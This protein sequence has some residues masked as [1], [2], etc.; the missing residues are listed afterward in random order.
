MQITSRDHNEQIIMPI[1]TAH[2]KKTN[3]KP[4]IPPI[5]FIIIIHSLLAEL[6]ECVC[7]S[8][9]EHMTQRSTG[10]K[11]SIGVPSRCSTTARIICLKRIVVPVPAD[12]VRMVPLSELLGTI[13]KVD[14]VL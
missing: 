7:K 6:C 13:L 14:G 10:T 12:I 2:R 11:E 8:E 1:T 5:Y 4:L 9:R 3:N